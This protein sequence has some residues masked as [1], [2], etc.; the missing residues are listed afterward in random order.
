VISVS[1]EEEEKYES[2]EDY[3]RGSFKDH[4]ERM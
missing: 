4:I 2:P 3:P 1:R